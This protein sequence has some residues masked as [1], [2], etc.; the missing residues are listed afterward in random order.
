MA[1]G[2]WCFS[3]PSEQAAR[4]HPNDHFGWMLNG[5]ALYR[6]LRNKFDLYNGSNDRSRPIC[7]ETFPHAIACALAGEIVPARDKRKVRRKLLIDAS[8]CCDL[9]TNIDYVDAALCALTAARFAQGQIEKHGDPI[10]GF[11]VVPRYENA[12]A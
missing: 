6:A 2:I 8:V 5:A 10:E 3:T 9:L 7:F 1:T 4:S 11:I 12:P